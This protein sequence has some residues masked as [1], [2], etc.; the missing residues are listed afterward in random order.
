[1]LSIILILTFFI[2]L[3][4]TTFQENFTPYVR[5]GAKNTYYIYRWTSLAILGTKPTALSYG[6]TVRRC[7]ACAG[8]LTAMGDEEMPNFCLT[9]C[10]QTDKLKG[11][12]FNL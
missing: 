2:P 7:G 1:M 3:K 8:I 6:G 12:R 10:Y 4:T 5:F 11:N 9:L